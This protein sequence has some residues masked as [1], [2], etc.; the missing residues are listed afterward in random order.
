MF[1]KTLSP[2]HYGDEWVGPRRSLLAL[3]SWAI[4]RARLGGWSKARPARL[5]EVEKQRRA[6]ERDVRSAHGDVELPLLGNADVEKLIKNWVPDVYNA[7]VED[8]QQHITDG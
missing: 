6:L 8:I 1:T 2:H 5:R 7:L 3:R 4:W